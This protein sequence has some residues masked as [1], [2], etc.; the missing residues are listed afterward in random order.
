MK[1]IAIINGANLNLLG[2][3][4]PEVYGNT[5][6]DSYFEMLKQNFNDVQITCIQTNA[7]SEIV[8]ALHDAE[9]HC[10]GVLLNAGGFSHTSV[11]IRDAIAA[12]SIPVI[13]V[14]ISNIFSREYFRKHSLMSEVCQGMVSGFGLNSYNIAMYAIT[15][16][17]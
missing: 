12:I 7:E 2:G 10:D 14:H 13:E 11:A 3:R 17:I 8:E 1:N 6:F 15:K 5:S 4:E 16:T 9:R